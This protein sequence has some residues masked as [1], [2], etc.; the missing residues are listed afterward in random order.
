MKSWLISL[1]LGLSILAADTINFKNGA[2]IEGKITHED[3]QTVTIRTGGSET[4]YARRDIASLS[5]NGRTVSAPPPPPVKRSANGHLGS[6]VTATSRSRVFSTGAVL[7]AGTAMN[8]R[9]VSTIDSSQLHAGSSVEGRLVNALHDA[10]GRVVA[11]ANTP[12]YLTIVDRK[13]AGR[14][15][16]HSAIAVK[17][18]AI[19]IGGRR[20]GIDSNVVAIEAKRSETRNT[21][22]RSLIGAGIGAIA[23]DDD[24]RRGARKGALVGLGVSALSKGEAAKIAAGTTMTFSLQH[25]I[26]VE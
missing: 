7:R 21:A 20:I 2:V 14:L 26:R 13:Q 4:T 16:G 19:V 24:R 18:T 15:L 17:A 25:D 12:V 8:V 9:L 11:P 1:V 10:S 3:D 6:E 22:R 5:R 23:N